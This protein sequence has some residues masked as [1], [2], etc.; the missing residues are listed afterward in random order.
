MNA[1]QTLIAAGLL[2]FLAVA[3]G[4]FGA[5]A[6]KPSLLANNRL[7]I[8]NLAVHYQ[9]YHT[10]AL[11]AIALLLHQE[12]KRLLKAAGVFMVVG[13]I[14]FSGSLYVM[15]IANISS[16]GMITPLGGICFLAGWAC[17]VGSAFK[18]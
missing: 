5:H 9:F 2:G 12:E 8:F 6:L 7:D 18:K 1:K 11:L 14:F 3:L 16:L 13:I 15:A 4:A 17:L 10:L